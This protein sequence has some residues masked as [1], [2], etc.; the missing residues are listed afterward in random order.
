MKEINGINGVDLAF[1][2]NQLSRL[3]KFM[4]AKKLP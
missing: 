3:S 2:F 1:D 4:N